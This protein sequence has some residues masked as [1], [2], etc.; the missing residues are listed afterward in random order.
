MKLQLTSVLTVAGLAAAQLSGKVGPTTSRDAK[1]AKK[2]CN[3]LNY[4]G[5]ASATTDNSV[6]VTKAW[7]DCKAGGQVFIPSG[8]YGLDKWVSLAGGKGVSINLEGVIF[9][10]SSGT[11]PGALITVQSADDFEF[12][13][14]NSKGAIQ[15]YGFELHKGTSQ[16]TA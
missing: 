6:A 4:G 13:S 9:R 2:I 8:S 11:A 1:T 16:L 15:G 10:I 14:G 3:V 5:A 7:E 12:Y